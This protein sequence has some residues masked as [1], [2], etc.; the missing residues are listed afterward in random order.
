M[1]AELGILLRVAW[2]AGSEVTDVTALVS[3]ELNPAFDPAQFTPPS[4]SLIGES[5][6]ETLGAGGPVWWA[7]KTAAG[8]AAGGTG[9]WI[10]YSPFGHGLPAAA[11]TEDA[12][13]EILQDDPAPVLSQAGLPSGPLVSAE[14]L[15][16]LQESRTGEFSATLHHGTTS[17]SCCHRCRQW[18]AGR[19]RRARPSRRRD[20]PAAVC[21][22]PGLRPPHRRA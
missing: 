19:L 1:D 11:T 7:A 9:V 8:L 20:N 6:G 16:L 4:G 22:S 15:H 2:M 21:L 3:L 5:L 18:H 17:V 12:E 10:R 14:V 13:A